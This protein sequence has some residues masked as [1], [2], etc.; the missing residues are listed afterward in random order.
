M[1]DS[2]LLLTMAVE[3]EPSHLEEFRAAV[4]R[5]AASARTE[6]GVLGYWVGEDVADSHRYFFV[7][8][9]ADDAALQRHQATPACADYLADLPGWLARPTV[10][11]IEHAGSAATIA[12][13]P[14]STAR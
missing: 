10:A 5:L 12:L 11:T 6:S 13:T 14:A 4:E 2:A 1:D 9:Y 8:R 3:I 7:E